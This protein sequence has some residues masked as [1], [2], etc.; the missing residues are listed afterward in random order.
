MTPLLT[1][2]RP[3]P[4]VLD[5]LTRALGCHRALAA[6]L[7]NR[8]IRTPDQA[9]HF[10]FPK[11]VDL[12]PPFAMAGMAEAVDRIASAVTSGEKILVFGDYDADGVTAGLLLQSFLHSAGN[13]AGLYIPHRIEEGYGL[14]P[15]HV[16]EMAAVA[17]K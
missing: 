14:K 15:L 7:A 12:R 1:L 3:E 13:R 9:R 16:T 4:A 8:G 2:L 10:L 6:I 11:L 17:A 5:E